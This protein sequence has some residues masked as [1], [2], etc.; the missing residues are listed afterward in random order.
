MPVKRIGNIFYRIVDMDNL[1]LAAKKACA[2][3]KDRN[4]VEAF[5]RDQERKLRFLRDDLLAGSY[6][7]S[8]YR[9]F[10]TNE[11][12][13]E[14]LV[15][16][17]PLY[18]DR[19]LHWAICLVAEEPLN[20]TLIKQTYGSVPGTGHHA[21]VKK[22]YDYIQRD[23]R[24]RYALS[25][26][27]RHFFA[28]IDKD[29]LKGK[30]R[31]TFKDRLFIDLIDIIIDGYDL[32]GIPIG[33]RT[34]PMLA[35]L[36]L[37]EIDHI[38]K[39]RFHCHYYVRY[40]DDIVVLG[41]S[42]KWLHRIKRILEEMMKDVNLE[43]KGNWQVYPIDSRGIQFLGYR[44]FTDHILLKKTTKQRM[45]TAARRIKADLMITG[46]PMDRHDLGTVHSYEGVLRWC[47]GNNL[48]KQVLD[49]LYRLDDRNL[50]VPKEL[51]S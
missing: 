6:V 30:I 9:M 31:R 17:C 44:I 14:R 15:A 34:S 11:N 26:D 2:S 36:Y 23:S 50:T 21:A 3:R 1:R 39:E 12:G 18:P 42:T 19:I 10:V 41:Y 22:V 43:L 46:R 51:I 13:K 37:S 38:M 5:K 32:P 4:E 24:A 35:N 29:V 47:D 16:D 27:V 45:K 7:P 20:R 49:P 28:S 8:E 40:M 25:I 48:R 33:N